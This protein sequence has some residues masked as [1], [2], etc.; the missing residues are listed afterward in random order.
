L[1]AVIAILAFFNLVPIPPLD[2]GGMLGSVLPK[3]IR[4]PYTQFFNKYGMMAIFGLMMTGGLSWVSS[5]AGAYIAL[6]TEF[7][8]G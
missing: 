1:L 2:G 6:I 5:L 3:A 4:E 7:I 8:T